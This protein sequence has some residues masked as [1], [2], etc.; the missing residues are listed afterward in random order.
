[1]TKKITGAQVI[2]ALETDPRYQAIPSAVR[3]KTEIYYVA[4]PDVLEKH[5]GKK[6][7]LESLV[8][9]K[10]AILKYFGESQYVQDSVKAMS[11][12]S[13]LSLSV[14]ST[15]SMSLAILAST[16][17]SLESA[18][19]SINEL[20][21]ASGVSEERLLQ[22]PDGIHLSSDAIALYREGKLTIG[23][24]LLSQPY[25]LIKSS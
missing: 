20:I 8:A 25:E 13:L 14:D 23:D 2:A 16:I 22:N 24:V 4:L 18:L 11:E 3:A 19:G 10:L 12:A 6:V 17:S 1:M 15:I 5:L 7:S 21:S 9:A